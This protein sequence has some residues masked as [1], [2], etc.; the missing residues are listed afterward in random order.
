M[1]SV[2]W[3]VAA[4]LL[5]AIPWAYLIGKWTKGIDI[6]EYGSGNVGFTN[7]LRIIGKGPA[8]LV[9]IGDIGKG[10]LAVIL[11]GHFGSPVLAT[12]AGL[13]VVVG[14]N[15]P[16]F[17]GFRGGKGA[18]AGFGALIALL[19]FEAFMAIIIWIIIVAL[20]RYVSLGTILG[21]LSVP[22]MTIIF[23]NE[24]HYLLFSFLGAAFVIF[25]HH[26][27]ISR[28]LKGTERKIGKG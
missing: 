10:I 17:L 2:L 12:M 21:A 11:A 4:Y 16:V 23:H 9:L 7:A 25:K 27:N 1:V 8:I 24:I 3:L 22:V 19:P 28:L 6:R 18:A 26:S 13:A 14:H 5:G 15:Y 20:T